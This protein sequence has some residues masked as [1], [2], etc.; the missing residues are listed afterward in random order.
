MKLLID[1]DVFCK[2]GICGLLTEA[3]EI[4]NLQL[5]DCGRLPTLPYMLR[6]GRLRRLY[7]QEQCDALLP[8]CK[9]I[10]A[11]VLENE[12]WLDRLTPIPEVDPGEA[13]IFATAAEHHMLVMTG[14][15]RALVALKN[16]PEFQTALTGRI[17]GFEAILIAL[18]D[19][20]GTAEMRARVEPLR[21]KDAII[22]VC[23]SD[24]NDDPCE[25]LL[26]YHKDLERSVRPLQLWDPRS[27]GAS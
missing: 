26:S 23:F 18:C 17:I 15:K 4:F 25:G 16:L 22:D 7:G 13:L 10:P 11:V 5:S 24:G 6:R 14:D 2:L 1:T 27:K 20:H 3:I 8:T 19:R 21:P 12:Q 9:K